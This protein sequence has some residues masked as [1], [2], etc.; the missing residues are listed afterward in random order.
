MADTTVTLEQEQSFTV[1]AQ[2]ESLTTTTSTLSN[3][4]VVESLDFVGDIDT[5]SNG[6]NNGS[7]LVYRTTT[8]RWTSTTTLDAQ[9][10]EGGEF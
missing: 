1:T 5:A 7:I 4:S 6:K 8:N 2:Q 3:P 9:N 10:M